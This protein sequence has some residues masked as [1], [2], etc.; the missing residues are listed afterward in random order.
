MF[1]FVKRTILFY[2]FLFNKFK[3]TIFVIAFGQEMRL[4][5]LNFPH[6]GSLDISPL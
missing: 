1:L 2:F 3:R 4:T 5:S 6:L